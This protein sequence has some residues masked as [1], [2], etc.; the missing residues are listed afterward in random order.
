MSGEHSY[1]EHFVVAVVAFAYMPL[2]FFS[3]HVNLIIRLSCDSVTS[4]KSL[5]F[6]RNSMYCT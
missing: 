2:I 6:N 4:V 3:V 1:F 5:F